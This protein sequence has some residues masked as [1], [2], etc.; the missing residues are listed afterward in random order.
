[1]DPSPSSMKYLLEIERNRIKF[2]CAKICRFAGGNLHIYTYCASSGTHDL[3]KY[4]FYQ[5]TREHEIQGFAIF[6]I[7]KSRFKDLC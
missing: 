2:Y 5:L 1:M 7:K 6:Y 3:E 4:V